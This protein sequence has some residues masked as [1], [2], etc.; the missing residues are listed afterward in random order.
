MAE[1]LVAN[2]Y[3]LFDKRIENSTFIVLIISLCIIL[4][5]IFIPGAGHRAQADIFQSQ[6]T[7]N[8]VTIDGEQYEIV[9]KK[10]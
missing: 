8:I 2:Y 7:Q 4:A 10:L 5:G 1:A 6:T 3:N 9:L